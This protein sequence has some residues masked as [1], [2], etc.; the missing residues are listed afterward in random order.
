M[1]NQQKLVQFPAT[2][3]GFIILAVASVKNYKTNLQQCHFVA[4]SSTQRE[5]ES[6][7]NF[8]ITTQWQFPDSV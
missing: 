2:L 6:R 3:G 7:K 1:D 4:K 5:R 8:S